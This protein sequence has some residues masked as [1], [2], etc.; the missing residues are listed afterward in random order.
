MAK[1]DVLDREGASVGEV[2]LNETIFMAPI[3]TPVMHQAVTVYLNSLRRGTHAVKNR[4]AVSGGG[5]KPWRQ[6]GTGRASFGS[7]R[8]P[9]WR[10]GGVAFGPV[11]RSYKISMPKKMRRVALLSALSSKYADGDLIVVDDLA[12]EAPKTKE[13]VRIMQNIS[14]PNALIVLSDGMDNTVLSARNV[15]GLNTASWDSLNTYKILYNQKL[16]ITKDALT[17][18]EEVLANA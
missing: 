6:Q 4:S 5:K 18:L 12:M 1:I 15:T 7:S 16:V 9:V 2:E 17:S 11:P 8:N 13:L 14:A 10:G 3:N